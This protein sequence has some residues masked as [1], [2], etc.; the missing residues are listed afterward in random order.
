MLTTNTATTVHQRL[1]DDEDLA[2]GLTSFRRYVWLEFPGSRSRE[3]ATPYRPDVAPGEEAQI[4]YG[5]LGTWLDPVDGD[6][7]RV[8][9]SPSDLSLPTGVALERA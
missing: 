4:D 8:V 1:R 2:V 3:L 7:G 9:P 5:Y 6:E